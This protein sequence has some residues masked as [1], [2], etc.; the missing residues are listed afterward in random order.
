MVPDV[1]AY[2]VATVPGLIIIPNALTPSAQ[3]YLAA[4]SL[5]QWSREPNVSNLHAHWDVPDHGI[6]NAAQAQP[7]QIIPLKTDFPP[8][9]P[10]SRS[11]PIKDGSLSVAAGYEA[12]PSPSSVDLTALSCSELMDRMR[13]S[14]LGMQYNWSRQEY[15]TDRVAPIPPLLVALTRAIVGATAHLTHYTADQWRPQGG[16][17]NFYGPHDAL[18]AHQDRSEVN[19]TAPLVSLSLGQDAVFLMGSQTRED[20]PTAFRVRS[21]DIILFGGP[22]RLNF[23][24]VPRIMARESVP[25][26]APRQIKRAFA[27]QG[28]QISKQIE[29]GTDLHMLP[30]TQPGTIASCFSAC[31]QSMQKYLQS[32]R[33]NINVRQFQ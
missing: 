15:Y 21:G 5:E 4:A 20:T 14:S 18:M 10:S 6:W 24:G 22:A 16:I 1:V 26:H 32:H 27:A 2:T 11:Q 31:S 19:M 7:D 9:A 33:I 28:R 3:C 13:W 17:I 30:F 12:S 23:H 29:Q 25:E 8:S